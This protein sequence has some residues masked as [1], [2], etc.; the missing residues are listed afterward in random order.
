MYEEPRERRKAGENASSKPKGKQ[1]G[2]KWKVLKNTKE[3]FSDFTE[4][5]TRKKE[6]E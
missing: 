6:R 5:E 1:K 2:R 4:E 3:V